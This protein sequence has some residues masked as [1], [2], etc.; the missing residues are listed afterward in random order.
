MN[1]LK[2]HALHIFITTAIVTFGILGMRA[3]MA[4]KPEMKKGKPTVK[5]PMV[6][7]I[8]VKTGGK[9]IHIQGEGTVRPVREIELTPQVA[10][11]IVYISPALINGGTF[12]EGETLLRVDPRD[13]RLAITLAEAGVKDAESH[14]QLTQQEAATAREEWEQHTASELTGNSKP[15]PLV[16]KE[17][18][19]AAARAKL[20]ASR[21]ELAKAALNLERT[22]IKAP[23]KGRIA[24]ENVD[25]GQYVSPG[26]SLATLYSTEA[27]QIV[28]PFEDEK[29]SWFHVPGFTDAKG[30]GSHATV[31][32]FL[33][34][35]QLAWPGKVVRSEGKL[36]ERTRMINVVVEVKEPYA[37]MPPLAMGL[38]VTVDIKGRTLSNAATIPRSALHQANLVWTVDQESRLRFREVEVALIQGSEAVIRTGLKNGDRL[39]TTPLKTVTDGMKVRAMPQAIVQEKDLS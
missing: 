18:Q 28:L 24:K 22:E 37:K 10:G 19:L 8:K 38:F 39:V 11:T 2:K 1:N 32:T 33:A 14:L 6:R 21:A 29:L 31:H 34:G 20:S 30:P 12:S 13:Y 4:G 35:R 17:P 27:A 16:A 7:T 15:S 25:I 9:T 36:D 26:K 5:A 3:L 23:F